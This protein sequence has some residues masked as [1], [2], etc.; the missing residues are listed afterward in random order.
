MQIYRHQSHLS[1]V[2]V[3]L[4]K[5][6]DFITTLNKNHCNILLEKQVC[7]A[8]IAILL[9]TDTKAQFRII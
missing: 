5:L 2:T 3:N 4:T 7:N 9:L 1:K 8:I 6:C